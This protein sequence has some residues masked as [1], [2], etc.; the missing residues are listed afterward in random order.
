M[1]NNDYYWRRRNG[2]I[3]GGTKITKVEEPK[4]GKIRNLSENFFN[5][6]ES[7]ELKR[8]TVVGNFPTSLIPLKGYDFQRFVV[9]VPKNKVGFNI[10]NKKVKTSFKI[11]DEDIEIHMY[12]Y[13]KEILAIR[14]HVNEPKGFFS[15]F[16]LTKNSK[17]VFCLTFDT[18][19]SIPQFPINILK[20]YGDELNKIYIEIGLK[21]SAKSNVFTPTFYQLLTQNSNSL[22]ALE[23]NTLNNFI[24]KIKVLQERLPSL[25]FNTN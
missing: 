15:I 18:A 6:I 21:M 7:M 24:Q 19:I 3:G 4:K 20:E 11:N 14:Y 5:N 16:G 17:S 2:K 8:Y 1:S 13:T 25:Y 12:M 22:N 23:P 9:T 10:L